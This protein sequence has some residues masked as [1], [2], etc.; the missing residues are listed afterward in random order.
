MA[1]PITPIGPHDALV[2]VDVQNDFIKGNVAIEGASEIIPVI[3]RLIPQF[4]HVVFTLDWHPPG[5]ISF[6]STHGRAPGDSVR[7]PYGFQQLYADHC[8]QHTDGASLDVRLNASVEHMLVYKG[9]RADVDSFSAF[10]ENDRVT[11]TGLDARL[12]KL[13]IERVVLVGLALYGCVRHTALDARRA[14]F[15]VLIIDD[16][17]RARPSLANQEYSAELASAFVLRTTA[18]ALLALSH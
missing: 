13:R 4:A 10:M 11:S 17:C 5:H 15:D 1:S 2:V 7:V 12:H 3:N 8:V 6:A 9:T 18:D 16:A 14:G